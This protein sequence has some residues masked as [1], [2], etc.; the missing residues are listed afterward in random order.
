[1]I[2]VPPHLG[3]TF[4]DVPVPRFRTKFRNGERAH[5]PVPWLLRS[6]PL[7]RCGGWSTWPWT[8][9][10][11]SSSSNSRTPPTAATSPSRPYGPAQAGH[12][13]CRAV[14]PGRP[15]RA[16]QRRAEQRP[17]RRWS[18]ERVGGPQP[19]PLRPPALR[20]LGPPGQRQAPQVEHLRHRR[21]QPT[22][23]R[24]LTTMMQWTVH[25]VPRSPAPLPLPEALPQPQVR[26]FA[27]HWNNGTHL[28]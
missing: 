21:P 16:A 27:L 22:P 25:V 26:G 12:R 2:R 9:R 13:G 18:V 23:P 28:G 5:V 11:R 15:L 4:H 24:G 3:T 10:R 6:H 14:Q 7:R 19:G 20:L 8:R 17:G 1:M